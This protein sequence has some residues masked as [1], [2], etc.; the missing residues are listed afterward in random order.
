MWKVVKKFY[1]LSDAAHTE[2]IA[3][4]EKQIDARLPGFC[5]KIEQ[6]ESTGP[7]RQNQ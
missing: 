7:A 4:L 2:E 6:S 5:Q 1:R 3:A